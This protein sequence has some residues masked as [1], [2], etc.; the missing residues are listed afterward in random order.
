MLVVDSRDFIDGGGTRALST[1][2]T[3]RHIMSTV[4]SGDGGN[5][6]PCEYFNLIGATGLS[7]LCA[8]LFIRFVSNT[9]PRYHLKSAQAL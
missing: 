2:Y 5:V 6:R 1:L 9:S 3:L 7:G 4:I 8:L